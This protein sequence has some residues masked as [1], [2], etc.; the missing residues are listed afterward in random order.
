MSEER[1]L[2]GKRVL[3]L[4]YEYY[5]YHNHIRDAIEKAGA[6]LDYFSVRKYHTPW[7]Y[8][9][10]GLNC[11]SKKLFVEFNRAYARSILERTKG[12][13][14]DYVFVVSGWQLLKD[15][16]EEL[17][18]RNPN[19]RFLNYHW[20][21]VR[22]TEFGITLLDLVPLFDRVYSF[23][24]QDCRTYR[25]LHYL[26]LFYVKQYCNLRKE[27]FKEKYDIDILFIGSL[28]KYRRYRYVMDFEKLCEKQGIRFFHYMYVSKRFY[29]R[30][31]LAGQ[32]MLKVH[33]RALSQ[34]G[35]I[36]YYR[37]AKA[38]LDLPQQIQTGLAI[39][40][41]EVLGAGKKLI[42]TNKHIVEEPFYDPR[43]ILIVDNE[44]PFI[45]PAFV[46]DTE[47]V[48]NDVLEQYSLSNW[49]KTIFDEEI[50]GSSKV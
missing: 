33:S 34:A 29:V 4:G 5:D 28:N 26:P 13:K 37:R 41:F 44:N 2:D 40:V 30:S 21:S 15:F 45:D 19:A 24:R 16:Y 11:T 22:E 31:F 20:D 10:W 6:V 9:Y 14:Y 42:T 39:R 18:I 48:W 3:F 27:I 1:F 49:V 47:F 25:G 7:N 36:R 50:Y 46:M 38:I 23:D 12:C 35:I 43:N 8:V 17:R 32:L